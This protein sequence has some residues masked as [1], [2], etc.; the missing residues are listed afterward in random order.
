ME[1][2]HHTFLIWPL[3]IFADGR[4]TDKCLHV[5]EPEPQ[6]SSLWPVTA[7]T[8]LTHILQTKCIYKI[9]SCN[10]AEL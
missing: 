4:L 7:L 1:A 8:D 2:E 3:E 9:K 5:P 10:D 6:L